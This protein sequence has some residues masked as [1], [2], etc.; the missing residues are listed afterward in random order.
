MEHESRDDS[1]NTVTYRQ[2]SAL[3]ATYPTERRTVSDLSLGQLVSELSSDLSDL[4]RQEVALARA[5]TMEKVS[6]A[7]QGAG[8]MAGGGAVA[9]AGLILLLIAAAFGLA[10]YM[11]FWLAALIVGVVAIVVGLILAL[12]GRGR[13]REATSAPEKTIETMKDNAEFVKEKMQ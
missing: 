11:P 7:A 1:R 8:L 6:A 12:S 3:D 2:E 5:E 4:I 9:Y 13:L 10:N